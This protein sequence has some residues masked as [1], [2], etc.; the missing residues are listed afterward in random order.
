[1][2][3]PLV[4][5]WKRWESQIFIQCIFRRWRFIF[6]GSMNSSRTPSNSLEIQARLI[7][8]W[9]YGHPVVPPA[10]QLCPLEFSSIAD[11]AHPQANQYATFINHQPWQYASL[12]SLNLL[13]SLVE[14]K[15]NLW[16]HIANSGTI[17]VSH[18]PKSMAL[19]RHT[20]VNHSHQINVC[21]IS[22]TVCH[23]NLFLTLEHTYHT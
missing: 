2:V 11:L 12:S 19:S 15:I 3:K 6:Q 10:P 9:C 14:K 23:E 21:Y 7:Q 22:Y 4:K 1:M 13:K 8:K 16:I 18:Q 5:R 20:K 17:T